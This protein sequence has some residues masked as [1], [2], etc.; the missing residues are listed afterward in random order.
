[1][2][3]NIVEDWLKSMHLSRYFQAF[4]DNGYDDLEVCKQIGHPD[5]DAIGVRQ[6]SHRKAILSAV[7]TLREQGGTHVY[8]TLENPADQEYQGQGQSYVVSTESCSN[9]S[10]YGESEDLAQEE[11][12]FITHPSSYRDPLPRG[13]RACE[14]SESSD[15]DPE[16]WDPDDATPSSADLPGIEVQERGSGSLQSGRGGGGSSRGEEAEESFSSLER[17]SCSSWGSGAVPPVTPKV[18][19]KKVCIYS[20]SH[21]IQLSFFRSF[22]VLLSS[23]N[24]GSPMLLSK[25]IFFSS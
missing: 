10:D 12:S 17:P 5:L 19:E 13:F 9:T 11:S 21:F 8:F 1:M 23:M 22:Y 25:K 4:V 24:K 16:S 20:S 15:S 7:L 6:V 14:Y 2:E 18:T 3:P